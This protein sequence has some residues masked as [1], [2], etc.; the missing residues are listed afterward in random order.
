MA[1]CSRLQLLTWTWAQANLRQGSNLLASSC[2]SS[3]S[4]T[5]RGL[6]V[7]SRQ[8]QTSRRGSTIHAGLNIHNQRLYSTKE[9]TDAGPTGAGNETA[10]DAV[11]GVDDGG[12][13]ECVVGKPTGSEETPKGKVLVLWDLDNKPPV[14]SAT[15]AAHG[16][17][18]LAESFGEVT[19]IAAYA[20]KH[21]FIGIRMKKET[22]S[23]RR[24]E[25]LSELSEPPELS[26]PYFF[27]GDFLSPI[28]AILGG[29]TETMSAE[30]EPEPLRCHVC[31]QKSKNEKALR[32]HFERLHAREQKKK[33]VHLASVKGAAK[34]ARLFTKLQPKLEKYA[35]GAH[36]INNPEAKEAAA[37]DGLEGL[38]GELERAGVVVK[39]VAD[40]P[41][42][43]DHAISRQIRRAART[44]NSKTPAQDVI[45]RVVLVS[46]DKGFVPELS[47]ARASGLSTHVI[48]TKYYRDLAR[49]KAWF[50]EF[51]KLTSL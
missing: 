46:D 28:D 20:N 26:E 13:T 45:H 41:D 29:G 16:L 44:R 15:D 9:I 17:R 32:K 49:N 47:K 51:K 31:G 18:R 50:T 11:L 22:R 5:L 6:L 23:R 10:D 42:T 38:K 8:A 25:K 27:G 12:L 1:R 34:K 40:G 7:S 4:R 33:L 21:A 2:H 19:E 14:G 39:T 36:Y 3:P 43:A 48:G 24:L 30:L 37:L 35:L